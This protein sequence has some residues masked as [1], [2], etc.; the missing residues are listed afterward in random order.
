MSAIRDPDLLYELL[1]ESKLDLMWLPSGVIAWLWDRPESQINAAR[2]LGVQAKDTNPVSDGSV[3]RSDQ[4]ILILKFEDGHKCN[5]YPDGGYSMDGEPMDLMGCMKVL[6]GDMEQVPSEECPMETGGDIGLRDEVFTNDTVAPAAADELA[7]TDER[8]EMSDAVGDDEDDS[9]VDAICKIRS[10]GGP[11]SKI[12]GKAEEAE[13]STI[14]MGNAGG[15]GMDD[16]NDD[17][18]PDVT[19]EIEELGRMTESM[20]KEYGED[21]PPN[22]YPLEIKIYD[23]SRDQLIDV[24]LDAYYHIE[25]KETDER[26]YSYYP[27][28]PVVDKIVIAQPFSVN[29]RHYT[30]GMEFPEEELADGIQLPGNRY[31]SVEE[32]AQEKLND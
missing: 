25:E 29:N 4:N 28:D 3:L 12:L 26:G 32:Y 21:P 16:I 19:Q 15:G 13:G 5:V 24:A 17:W 27:G 20:L 9:A 11:M 23:D 22:P 14:G 1:C 7:A 10:I 30:A 6:N 2:D 31:M 18:L 8:V